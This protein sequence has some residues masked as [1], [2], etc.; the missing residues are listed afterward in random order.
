[1]KIDELKAF[2]DEQSDLAARSSKD[3]EPEWTGTNPPACYR[4]GMWYAFNK[5]KEFIEQN[6]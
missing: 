6:L 1:M 3:W 2:L 4:A 5:V